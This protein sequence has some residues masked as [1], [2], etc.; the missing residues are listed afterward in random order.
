M[1]LS[2]RY[3]SS[4][5]KLS[6]L[7]SLNV[8]DWICTVVLLRSGSFYEA[9]PLAGIFIGDIS[10]GFLM[11]CVLPLAVILLTARILSLLD[12]GDMPVADSFISFGIV[13]YIAINLDH[14]MN[15]LLLFFGIAT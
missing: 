3:P 13:F 11:K 9:N 7:Y 6:I 15:F 12:G 14:I 8:A 2:V 10:W 1:E 5:K 4:M